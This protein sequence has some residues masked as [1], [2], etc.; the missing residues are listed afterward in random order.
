MRFFALA[1]A[2]L[3]SSAC[4]RKHEPKGPAKHYHLSGRV[5]S[6]NE[7]DQSASIDGNEI[8]GYM[9]AMTMDYPVANRSD[10]QKLHPGDRIEATLDVYDSGDY[11]LRDIHPAQAKSP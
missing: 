8:P 9:E 4:A 11:S 10:L 7:K 5:I 2:L 1:M 3:L 6:V